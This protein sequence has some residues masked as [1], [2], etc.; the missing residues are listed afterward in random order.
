MKSSFSHFEK[1]STGKGQIKSVVGLALV[2]LVSLSGLAKAGEVLDKVMAEGKMTVATNSEYPPASYLN[3]DGVFEG[4]D[5]DVAK[6]LAKRMGVDVEFINPAWEAITSG[7]WGGRWDVAIGSMTPTPARA[8]VLDFPAVYYFTPSAFYVHKDSSAQ[9][10]ADLND[11]RIGASGG[12]TYEAYLTHTLELD[13]TYSPPVTFSVTPSDIRTYETDTNAMDDLRIGDGKRLDAGISSVPNILEAIKAN[14][15]I[16]QL[17]DPVFYEPLAVALAKGDPEMT[18][19]TA[20]IIEEMRVD[21]T[22]VELSVK[23]FGEDLVSTT[24]N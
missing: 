1:K 9:T 8:E 21:G 23:W 7:K 2:G 18:A 15:P 6:E 11:K 13:Q 12:S 16:R 24:H 5:V 22:L 20:E 10:L 17:G 19:K 4:Y 14:Y 3:A